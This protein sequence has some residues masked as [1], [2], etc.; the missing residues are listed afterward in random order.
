MKDVI[1]ADM[2]IGEV[3]ALHPSMAGVLTSGGM[4]CVGCMA[5]SGET[6]AEAAMVHG[7][8]PDLLLARVNAFYNAIVNGQ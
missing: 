2:T 8:E 7:I 3:L 1:T 6:L 5:G 4:H